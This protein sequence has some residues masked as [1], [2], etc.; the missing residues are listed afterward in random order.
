[1]NLFYPLTSGSEHAGRHEE[2]ENLTGPP[3]SLIT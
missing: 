3:Y 1:M 2:G